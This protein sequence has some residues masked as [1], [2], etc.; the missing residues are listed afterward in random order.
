MRLLRAILAEWR[1]KNYKKLIGKTIRAY[2][3]GLA[4][5]TKARSDRT[6]LRK[7]R[8]RKKTFHRTLAELTAKD[9]RDGRRNRR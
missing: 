1:G 5:K 3:R 6:F 7:K 8:W 2:R 9:G 4:L